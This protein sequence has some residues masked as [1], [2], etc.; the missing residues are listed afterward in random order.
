MKK[1]KHELSARELEVL[2]L[3]AQGLTNKEIGNRL[4]IEEATV[5][6]HLS[7]IGRKLYLKDKERFYTNRV[8]IVVCALKSGIVQLDDIELPSRKEI[9]SNAA[10]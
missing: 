8:M 6:T 7:S 4:H 9:K 1:R 5:H 10:K 3:I 2:K